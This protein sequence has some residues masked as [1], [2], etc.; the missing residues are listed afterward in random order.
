MVKQ[1]LRNMRR[2]MTYEIENGIAKSLNYGQYIHKA[3]ILILS[4]IVWAQVRNGD[5]FRDASTRLTEH[6]WR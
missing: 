4:P 3:K 2:G 5:E 6:L 1:Q